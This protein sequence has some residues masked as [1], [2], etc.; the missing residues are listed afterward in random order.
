MTHGIL[1]AILNPLGRSRFAAPILSIGLALAACGSKPEQ[2]QNRVPAADEINVGEYASLTGGTATF[3]ISSHNG[4]QMAVEEINASGG[5]LGKKIKLIT[6]DTQSKAGE[7]STGVKKLIAQDKVIA[8]LGEVASSRSLEAGPIAQEAKIPLI[9][10]AS[11]NPKVTEVGDYIFRVCFID[12][13]QGTV[14]AKFTLETL[15]AKK[16]ALLTDVKQDYSVGLAQFYKQYFTKN[17][18]VLVIEQ[19]YSTGDKDFRAQ[20]SAIKAT[21]PEAIFLPGYYTEAATIIK[22]ARQMGITAPFMGGDGWDSESLVQI[23][24]KEAMEGNYFSNH[25]STEDPSPAIQAFV[26]NYKAKYNGATPD[27]M[28]ALGYDSAMILADAI[29]RAGTTDSAKLREAIASTKEYPAITGSITLN[30]K[31]DATKSAVILTIKDGQFKFLETVA[32]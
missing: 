1:S 28:A 3:G 12:P 25:F 9:S 6:E 5:V 4:T 16:V 7:A 20:L 31:R 17:G 22:Q 13:F 2:A 30:E 14:M 32:P 24:T 23:G 29:K 11:T 26:K 21:N 19:S 15:K 10:P 27:A 18:G 8:V